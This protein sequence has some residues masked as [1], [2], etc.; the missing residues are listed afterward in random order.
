MAM[1]TKIDDLPHNVKTELDDL[2]KIDNSNIKAD[3]KK[4]VSFEDDKIDKKESFLSNIYSEISEESILLI[5]ILVIASIQ[6]FNI[7]ITKIPIIGNYA[8]NDIMISIIKAIVLFVVFLLSK[9]L[10]IPKIKI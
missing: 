4:K 3:I 6:S 1:A 2:Q 8:N 7:Y 10:I 9:Y 5:C